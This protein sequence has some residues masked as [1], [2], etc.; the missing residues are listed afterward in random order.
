M[1]L[2]KSKKKGKISIYL[3]Q[4][5]IY[6]KAEE[7]I[8]AKQCFAIKEYLYKHISDFNAAFKIY[9]DLSLV[10]YMD[11]TFL[12]ILAGIE[13][14]MFQCWQNHLI[15]INPSQIAI[16]ALKEVGLDNF[17]QMENKNI[18]DEKNFKKFDDDVELSDLD[19]LK[20]IYISHTELSSLNIDNEKKF[21]NLQDFLK[22]QIENKK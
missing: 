7:H 2:M 9:L 19:K 15:I 10:D 1:H 6:L 17:I 21:K 16:K 20:I 3:Q 18:P 8:T 14:K 5:E 13:K 4:N 12:G 22:K 11:S